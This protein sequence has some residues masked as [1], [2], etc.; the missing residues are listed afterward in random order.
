[1]P[2]VYEGFEEAEHTARHPFLPHLSNVNAVEEIL[3]DRGAI[4]AL[5]GYPVRGMA[6]PF[7]ATDARIKELVRACGIAYARGTGVTGD[8]SLPKDAYDWSASCH[9]ADLEPLIAP[10]LRDASRISLLSVWGHSY[11]FDMRGDWE[12]FEGMLER[13]GGNDDI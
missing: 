3:S 13:L 9:H 12:K 1:M 2:A 11:E 5:V 7:G 10:F 4:E 6:Y 8:F